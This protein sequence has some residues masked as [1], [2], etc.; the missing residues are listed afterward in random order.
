MPDLLIVG[1]F[2]VLIIMIP[3]FLEEIQDL[4]RSF[5]SLQLPWQVENQVLHV[6]I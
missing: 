2:V 6:W 3:Q 1:D 4:G 5:I